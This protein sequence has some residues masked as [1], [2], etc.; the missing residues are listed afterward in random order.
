MRDAIH[1]FA[2][3][4]T[5]H[6]HWKN[7]HDVWRRDLG[8]WEID[9]EAALAYLERLRQTIEQHGKSLQTHSQAINSHEAALELHERTMTNFE[10]QGKEERL[11]EAAVKSHEQR[12]V[13]H[14]NQ[15][16]A[17]ERLK[18]EHHTLMAQL[19]VLDSAVAPK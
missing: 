10:C 2:A 9:Y 14:L 16:D 7:D 18:R 8:G 13:D 15:R 19:T 3:M 6:R 17:H 4:H 11:N 5:D 1:T 12:A